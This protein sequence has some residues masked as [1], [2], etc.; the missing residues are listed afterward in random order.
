MTRNISYIYCDIAA[1]SEDHLKQSILGEI[2]K[3]SILDQ[4]K[5]LRDGD[6]FWYE[7]PGVLSEEELHDLANFTYGD[8]VRLNSKIKY[9]PSN[10][11][12]AVNLSSLYFLYG[13]QNPSLIAKN[14]SSLGSTILLLDT[15]SFSW[16]IR[17][18]D[19]MIDFVFSSN[20]SG[21]F[22]FGF[23]S[24][25]MGADI[26]LSRDSGNG[27]YIVVDSYRYINNTC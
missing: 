22:G 3:A 5:R 15:L 14:S 4:F 8:M 9:F 1:F 19:G 10:P 27:T 6:R 11:F 20:S 13:P 23:G 17:K 16:T 21:W 12:V 26:Y 7:N 25:M 24:N 18:A 2:Q